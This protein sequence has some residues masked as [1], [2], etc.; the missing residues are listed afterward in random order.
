MQTLE[1]RAMNTAIVLAAEEASPAREGLE[2]ARA[3]IEQSEA[4]FSRFR[5][6]SELSMLNRAA[7]R[8]VTVSEDLLDLLQQSVGFSAETGGLFDPSILTD[9]KRMGYSRSMDEIREQGVGSTVAP[10]LSARSEFRDLEID[11]PQRRVR[12]PEAMEIDLGGIA[13][14]WIVEQA[15]LMLRRYAPGCAVSAGGDIVFAGYPLDGSSWRVGIEHPLDPAKTVA[16][17]QMGPG[18]IVTSSVA[19]R[20][21]RQAG[22]LRHHLIDPRT[23]E[24]AEND[25]LSVTVVAPRITVAEVYAKAILIGGP[26]QA[27]RLAAQRPEISY[28]AVSRDGTF[29]QQSSEMEYFHGLHQTY[30]Q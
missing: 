20:S 24:P 5:P 2:V 13:K 3:L 29:A 7:G 16:E 10:R 15:A 25:W 9:L 22:I 26:A 19:K 28:Y 14:G 11:S 1:F 18:A 12:L 27:E 4:R 23:G 21:W 6:D 8:W 30:Y 17:V